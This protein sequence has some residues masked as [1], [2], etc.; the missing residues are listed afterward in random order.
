MLQHLQW[1]TLQCRPGDHDVPHCIPSC[2][3]PSGTALLPVVPQ[4]QENISLDSLY[5]ELQCTEKLSS[6]QTLSPA[7][8]TRSGSQTPYTALSRT[9]PRVRSIGQFQNAVPTILTVPRIEWKQNQIMAPLS[10]EFRENVGWRW[11]SAWTFNFWLHFFIKYSGV[12]Q[13]FGFAWFFFLFL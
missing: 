7:I 2:G 13:C 1:L 6:P 8:N 4:K 9:S 12:F 5:L 10:K 3:H 11:N